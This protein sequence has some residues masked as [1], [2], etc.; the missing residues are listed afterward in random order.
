MELFL[1]FIF[2][3]II[4]VILIPILIKSA[5][6]L[7]MIDEPDER[8][9]HT[10]AVPRCGG[11]GLSIA[12]IAAVLIVAPF[13]Q[14]YSSLLV[15][16]FIIVLFGA[17]DDILN[18]HYK[19]K[20]LGQFIAVIFVI[21][22]GIYLQFLPFC[23]LAAGPLWIAY[24]LTFFFVVGVTNAVNLSDGLDGLAAGVTL[25]TLATIAFLSSSV[26][27]TPIVSLALIG[28]IL[29][30]LRFNSH[31]AIVFMGDTGSQFIGFMAAFLSIY[32][33]SKVHTT[34]NPAL[35]LLLLGLPVLDTLMV[36]TQRIAIGKSPFSPDKRHIH[37]KLLALGFS[38]A[39]AVAGI[40]LVQSVF[41]LMAFLLR[42]QSDFALLGGYLAICASIVAFFVWTQRAGWLFRDEHN[43]S[44]RRRSLF[45]RF[46]WLY[47]GCRLY[48]EYALIA[49]LWVLSITMWQHFAILEQWKLLLLISVFSLA[50]FSK[51]AIAEPLIRLCIYI[52]ATFSG[53]ILTVDQLNIPQTDALVTGFLLLL[54][55]AIALGIR[56]TRRKI[57]T[58]STQDILISLFVLAVA[59]LSDTHLP[60]NILFKLLCLG[61][62]IEY[63]LHFDLKKYYVLKFSALVSGIMVGTIMLSGQ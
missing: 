10:R 30:F 52:S 24:P 5:K 6:F 57:F 38:H 23:G 29:G 26:G 25:M 43:H 41:L 3:T 1:S 61:Y 48:I 47:H 55:L 50:A 46:D 13:E 15:G 58:L 19:W 27:G 40:Y 28:G 12:T 39:E 32:L 49:Y 62:G 4:S 16:G 63:L 17:L 36:M 37:H 21:Q 59:L 22:Q 31:P 18:L 35:P 44:D 8:K 53:F 42:Y 7:H 45:R 20:F 34:L 9:V 51:K 2:A 60:V 33:V 11:L 56:V 14:P 54:L